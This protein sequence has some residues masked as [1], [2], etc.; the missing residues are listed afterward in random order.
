MNKVTVITITYNQEKFIKKAL[1]SIVSQKTNFNFEVVVSDDCSTDSTPK[2]IKE[3]AKK[4]PKIIKPFLKEKNVGSLNNF[5]SALDRVNSQYIAFCDGDDYWCDDNKLQTQVDFLDNNIDYSMCFHQ[6]RVF[7]EAGERPDSVFPSDN[8]RKTS[9]FDDLVKEN[10]LPANSVMYRSIFNKKN[11]ASSIIPNYIDPG[12]YFVHLLHAK[13][14]KIYFINKVMSCYRRH[15]GGVW[16]LS[17]QDGKENEF[18]LKYGASYLKF[19]KA[20]ES[21][22]NLDAS[23]YLA[24]KENL[25]NKLSAIY[26]DRKM[27]DELIIL[28]NENEEMFNNKPVSFGYSSATYDRLSKFK[29]AIYLLIVSP[30]MLKDKA[31]SQLARNHITSPIFNYIKLIFNKKK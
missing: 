9:S 31:A 26:L 27:F 6:T 19:F 14:G 20:V 11:K 22:F 2:I 5:I 28:R 24:Q 29:K 17:C 7:F 25:I 13:T 1:D 12:D 30:T 18:M 3:Y 10:F 23:T 4:Y 16:W 15:N 21:T 8:F